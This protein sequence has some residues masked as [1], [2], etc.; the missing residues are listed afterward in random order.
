MKKTILILFGFLSLIRP[1]LVLGER[2]FDVTSFDEPFSLIGEWYFTKEDSAQNKEIAID[3]SSWKITR[4]PGSWKKIYQDKENFRVG[5]YRKTIRFSPELI[6]KEVVFLLDTYMAKVDV[7]LDGNEIFKRKGGVSLQRY[8]SIQ[9]MPIRFKITREDHVVSFRVDTILMKG[10]YQLP[11]E[12]RLYDAHDK[13]L[14][15]NQFWGGELRVISTYISLIAG[16]FFLLV[17]IKTRFGMY[18]N[19]ALAGLLIVPFFGAPGDYLV[20]IFDP[21]S[22]LII[23]YAGLFALL[24]HFRFSQYFYRRFPKVDLIIG[25]PFGL[26][27]LYFLFVAPFFFNLNLFQTIRVVFFITCLIVGLGMLYSYAKGVQQKRK[28]SMVMLIGTLI[29]LYTGVSDLLLA[30]D[31]ID[32]TGKIFIGTLVATGCMLWVVSNLFADTFVENKQLA[33]D[34]QKTN[35]NLKNLNQNLEIIVEERT[36]DLAQS[37]AEIK[38]VLDHIPLGV[39]TLNS[40]R[41][42]NQEF[43]AFTEKLFPGEKLIAGQG[44][45]NLLYPEIQQEKQRGY[46]KDFSELAFNLA[47]DWDMSASIA[48]KELDYQINGEINHYRMEFN[49]IVNGS[50][51]EALMLMINDITQQKKLEEKIQASEKAHD[52]EMKIIS[53]VINQDSQEMKDYLDESD[54][55][56]KESISLSEKYKVDQSAEICNKFFRLMHSLKGNSNAHDLCEIGD[57]AHQIEDV[58]SQMRCGELKIGDKLQKGPIAGDYLSERLE[59]LQGLFDKTTD[60]Y[61]KISGDKDKDLGKIRKDARTLQIEEDVLDEIL[62]Q[63]KAM[64]LGAEEAEKTFGELEDLYQRLFRFKLMKLNDFFNRIKKVVQDVSESRGKEIEFEIRGSEIYLHRKTHSEIVSSL[65]HLVRNAV[66]HGIETPEVRLEKNKHQK[67][68]LILDTI[69][70][71]GQ[72]IISIIDDGKGIDPEKIRQ[73]AVENGLIDQQEADKLSD[74]AAVNL[75]LRPGFSSADEVTE[76]S[77]RGV[78]MDV[79]VTSLKE[80]GGKLDI[81]SVIDQGTTFVLTLPKA[82]E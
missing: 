8:Y 43:S 57:V 9:P 51:V 30:L 23:H 13:T 72:L 40:Q 42:I 60:I 33:K 41:Q 49:R 12:I 5:W 34:L 4:A 78:G 55:I 80:V 21:E 16:L 69:E 6:G 65:I 73:V 35:E 39:M 64:H 25:I 75:I 81:H 62:S 76:I 61:Q 79:V 54:R 56:L 63:Y 11:F 38:S 3:T 53:A 27:G 26:M 68:R 74:E 15:W 19:A 32:S 28:G 36:A 18:L 58:L 10:V 22:L 2:V 47:M 67:G 1:D 24:F 50:E 20:K 37:K 70:E 52:Q 71:N 17:F 29:F 66:D 46:L 31:L 44:L 48:P 59:Y 14:A 45:E 82:T 7:Y 77:G